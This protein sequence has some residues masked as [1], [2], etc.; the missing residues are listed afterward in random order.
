MA[1]FA[2]FNSHTH[3]LPDD[4][5]HTSDN[6]ALITEMPNSLHRPRARTV[7]FR[8]LLHALEGGF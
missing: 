6:D 7:A 4:C 2:N 3:K 1:D 8:S 5:K